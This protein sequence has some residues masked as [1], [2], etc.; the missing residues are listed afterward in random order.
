MDEAGTVR[1]HGLIA[2]AVYR[3]GYQ[4][5]KLYT[6]FSNA[7]IIYFKVAFKPTATIG[8]IL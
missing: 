4:M 7:E 6:F 8:L 1:R 2:Q 5:V 3:E